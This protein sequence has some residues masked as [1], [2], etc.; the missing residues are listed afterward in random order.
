MGLILLP[1]IKT[2]NRVLGA[3]TVYVEPF[4]DIPLDFTVPVSDLEDFAKQ[5][6]I[7]SNLAPIVRHLSKEQRQQFQLLLLYQAP[8]CRVEVYQFLHSSLGES[9]L[10]L[11]AQGVRPKRGTADIFMLRAAIV[12]AARREDCQCQRNSA[13][14]SLLM[15]N[16]SQPPES[17][18]F[19]TASSY[20][21]NS[22][23]GL[24]P[25]N[26]L[27]KFFTSGV[28]INRRG[29][30]LMGELKDLIGKPVK[31]ITAIEQQSLIEASK[32]PPLPSL[33]DIKQ[34]GAVKWHKQTITLNDKKRNR[35]IIAD[36]YLPQQTERSP[37]IV[38]SHGLLGSRQDLAY[39]AEHLASYGFGVAVLEHPGSNAQHWLNFLQGLDREV[40]RP[41]EFIE[42]PL[43]VK[44][45]LNQLE[46]SF[47]E[48]LNFQKVGV[49]GQSFGGYTALALAGASLNFEQLHSE[50]QNSSKPVNLSM[51]LQCEATKLPPANY[52]LGDGR[53]KATMAINPFGSGLFG[54]AGMSNISTATMI[55]ASSADVFAPTF[56][57]QIR[58][59]SSLT[60][61][62]KYL[63]LLKGGTHFST[64]SEQGGVLQ[65]PSQVIGSHPEIAKEYMKALSVA[66]FKVYLAEAPAYKPY[67]MSKYAITINQ[68]Q[69]P[70]IMVHTAP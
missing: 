68:P 18:K 30:Q 31:A 33:P 27:K 38:I 23:E 51:L 48:Q 8:F 40:I 12:N 11:I 61:P 20:V 34:P 25:L 24:T 16:A 35:T 28:T 44:F 58:P 53:I 45:L 19:K 57:E 7:S 32:E 6:I 59:F 21:D 39:L 63:A 9:L 52:E 3:D 36:I 15:K 56:P 60:T 50:C 42:R 49:L 26:V 64:L 54:Q 2:P 69:I 5:G 55:V 17:C 10:G 22:S 4:D 66:F 65:L 29:L 37:L 67:L 41:Q 62:N 46:S 47:K 1:S 70:L 13:S 43:D 14:K